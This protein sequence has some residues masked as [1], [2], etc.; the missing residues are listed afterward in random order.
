MRKTLAMKSSFCNVTMHNELPGSRCKH[1]ALTDILNDLIQAFLL[2][3][4]VSAINDS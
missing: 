3:K 4:V 2:R 1:Y